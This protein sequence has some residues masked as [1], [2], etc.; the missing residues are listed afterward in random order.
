MGRALDYDEARELLEDYFAEAEEDSRKGEITKV[1]KVVAAAA[2]T[3]FKSNTQA[4]REAL[5]G[6]AI[7]RILDEEIDVSLP[8]MN[9]GE[10]AFNG[11]TLDETVV[12]PFLQ[13]KEIPCSKGPYLSALR[14][15]IS[16]VPETAK[17]LRD[18]DAYMAMLAII[19]ELKGAEQIEAQKYLSYLLGRFIELREKS[20]ITLSKLNRISLP[21]YSA[22]I[23]GL[24]D[25][26][27]GG[28]V[29]V[30]LSVA[31]LSALTDTYDLGW[32]I[33]FQG[34]N[35]ADAAGGKGGDVTVS[36]KGEVILA[37]EVTERQIDGDRVRSTFRTKIS[38]NAIEDYIFFFSGAE[39]T[40]EARE[41]ADRYFAQGHSI[42]FSSLKEWVLVLLQSLGAKGRGAF[43]GH[44]LALISSKETPAAV[45]VAWNE[46]VRGLV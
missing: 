2:D 37:I 14:R 10:D 40:A 28:L 15:N 39:P 4:F 9:Q 44:L 43:D 5:L 25:T 32:E 21:Q 1:P 26:P 13:E 41:R 27:S 8:Y 19:D 29:S 35:V 7:A 11:R 24:L 30:L 12:N 6:C 42:S 34:I 45:K 17:G 3:L 36:K 38:P 20:Q 16:F 46:I 22:L 18:K 31:A 23:Q 33:E